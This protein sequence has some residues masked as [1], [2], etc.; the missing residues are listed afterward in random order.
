MAPCHPHLTPPA[1]EQIPIPSI[2]LDKQISILAGQE[3]REGLFTRP[4]RIVGMKLGCVPLSASRNVPLAPVSSLTP[5][6][7][8]GGLAPMTTQST[9]PSRHGHASEY[10]SDLDVP[11]RAPGTLR[12]SDRGFGLDH[13]THV[14]H[15]A[16]AVC[17][18]SGKVMR[19]DHATARI[20]GGSPEDLVGRKLADVFVDDWD[21]V[22]A[23]L[24]R[25]GRPMADAAW[26]AVEASR[27][28]WRTS[29][30]PSHD[31]TTAWFKSEA[32]PG[33]TRNSAGFLA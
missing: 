26:Y 19:A 18:S 17:D 25:A 27:L 4:Q 28:P 14:E 23:G 20:L 22:D 1:E 30:P 2:P 31:A 10:P 9:C 6:S 15:E 33:G 24:E 32:H 8:G 21:V 7:P 3:D 11:V 12:A 13:F 16:L 29:S 5:P